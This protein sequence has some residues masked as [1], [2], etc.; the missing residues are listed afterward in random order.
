MFEPM[1][2]AKRVTSTV[3]V[4]E[5]SVKTQCQH[6]CFIQTPILL[7]CLVSSS[8]AHL[9]LC[10]RLDS[11]LS[12]PVECVSMAHLYLTTLTCVYAI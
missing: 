9:L 11:L 2:I 10:L 1:P 4:E 5:G 8:S 7:G 6:S 3:H 12:S